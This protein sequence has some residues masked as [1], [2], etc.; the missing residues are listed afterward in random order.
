DKGKA[1][2]KECAEPRTKSHLISQFKFNNRHALDHHLKP[3]LRDDLL[4]QRVEE[5][6]TVV[7]EWSNLFRRLPHSSI[8]SILKDDK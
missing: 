4:R 5:D 7:F 1:I 2:M 6:G 8:T 3:L